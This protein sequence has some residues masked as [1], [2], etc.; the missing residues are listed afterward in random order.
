MPGRA[1]AALGAAA[2]AAA[3]LAPSGALAQVYRWVDQR[4]TVYYTNS[5]ER[6][7]EFQPPKLD[8]AP[9]TPISAATIDKLGPVPVAPSVR[10]TRI[11][12]TPGAPIVVYA[13]IGGAGSL[14][15]ILDTGADRTMITPH[16]LWR[17]GISTAQAPLAEVR[18]VT[19]ASQGS[20]VRVPSLEVGDAKAGPLWVIAHE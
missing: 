19:G 4:G 2:L 10:I 6:L 18:G 8:L 7:P 16:A 12:Y 1:A 14:A 5:R 17:L 3:L 13:S 11:P 15:L 9:V 20:V